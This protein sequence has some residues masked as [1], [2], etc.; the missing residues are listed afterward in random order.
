M[1]MN[2]ALRL[3][4]FKNLRRVMAKQQ[5]AH[6]RKKACKLNGVSRKFNMAHWDCGTASCAIGSAGWDPWF[7][8]RGLK[9]VVG[10]ESEDRTDGGNGAVVYG[11]TEDFEAGCAFFGITRAESEFL[12]DP[13]QYELKPWNITPKKVI[14]RIDKL[15]AH[16]RKNTA[17]MIEDRW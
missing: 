14:E 1:S 15:A 11:M 5:R 12:F 6:T 16:Y 17:P 7:R 3:E 4:R 2:S 8:R 9:S 10:A 13:D